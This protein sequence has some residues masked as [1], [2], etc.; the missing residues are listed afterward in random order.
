MSPV[1]RALEGDVRLFDLE[2]EQG[3][4]AGQPGGRQARTLLKSGPLRVILIA[5]GPGG[6]T[7]EHQAEGPITVQP[8]RGRIRFTAG[9][10]VHEMGPGELLS[11]GSGVPHEVASDQGAVFL[12]TM[13]ISRP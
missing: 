2:Q 5:L 8:I 12:L 9:D 11:A 3:R 1:Q 10:R 6:T 4:L 13:G 7:A